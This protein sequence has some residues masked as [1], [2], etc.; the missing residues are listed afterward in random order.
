MV[1]NGA[2]GVK[3]MVYSYMIQHN[4]LLMSFKSKK[5]QIANTIGDKGS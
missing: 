1:D 2:K 4:S 5:A 3:L